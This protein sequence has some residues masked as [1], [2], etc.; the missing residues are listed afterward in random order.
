MACG[1]GGHGRVFYVSKKICDAA[2]QP[3]T[4]DSLV[5]TFVRQRYKF[6]NYLAIEW[7]NKMFDVDDRYYDEYIMN[8]TPNCTPK[9]NN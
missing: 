9:F 4:S 3:L 7:C 2:K 8:A 6:F 5:T 1:C